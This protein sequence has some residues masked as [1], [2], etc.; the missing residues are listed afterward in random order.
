[1]A[2]MTGKIPWNNS[3]IDVCGNPGG[4]GLYCYVT[5]CYP[6]AMG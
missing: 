3:L 4:C 6:F 1:M 5:H 2:L